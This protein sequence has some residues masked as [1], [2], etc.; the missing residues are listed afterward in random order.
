MAH[1]VTL[2]D[3]ARRSGV[4]RATASRA[5]NGRAGV[6]DDV[7]DR[8]QLIADALGYRPNRAAQNLAGG[9]ASVIG[10]V[11]GRETLLGDP[12]ATSLVQEVAHAADRRDEGLMFFMD[13][14][15]P[16]DTVRKLLSDGLVEGVIVSVVALGSMWVQ[17]LLDAGLPTVVIGRHPERSDVGVIDVEN[18]ESSAALVGHLLDSGCRRVATL[19]GP[20][21]RL[22][23]TR[24]LEGYRLAH[25]RRAMTVDERLVVTGTFHRDE[26]YLL[27]D[28]LL[29]QEPDAIFAANDQ[30]AMGVYDRAMERGIDIPGRL[31]LAGFDGDT[32]SADLGPRITS[33]SQPFE[34]LAERA[35]DLLIELITG[36]GGP[37][38]EL[39][40]PT[41]F[42]GD[43]TVGPGATSPDEVS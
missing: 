28:R 29:D 36:R 22:D 8:V 33:V 21:D 27:A 38:V 18:R 35:V 19:T 26:A 23:A 43:T 34:R 9:R 42:Y 24:R 6:R 30:S 12:Y 2:D 15:G 40:E 7:R 32:I 10:L 37:R 3:V 13:S 39:V 20:L 11:L 31:G 17:E 14:T 1:D 41:L 5:L 4:S 16:S 25:E